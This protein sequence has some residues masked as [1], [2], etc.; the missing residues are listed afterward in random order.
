[1]KRSS[2]KL[3]YSQN[4]L[5]NAIAKKVTEQ[6]KLSRTD[7]VVEIG[8]GSGQ[9]T[10]G[11]VKKVAAVIAIEQDY[12]LATKLGE[13]IGN[14]I[15]LITFCG[16]FLEFDLP[17]GVYKVVGNIPF[18]HTAQIVRKLTS[19]Q[20]T[21]ESSYLI[22]QLEAAQR[23]AGTPLETLQSLKLKAKFEIRVLMHLSPYAFI[24]RPAVSAALV[25][26]K[27]REVMA[28]RHLESY[29]TLVDQAFAGN[30]R[31][32]FR[33]L[34]KR[35]GYQRALQIQSESKVNLHRLRS[36]ISFDEWVRIAAFFD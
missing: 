2:Y 30:Y 9:L 23:Y 16:N 3:K 32:L 11:I 17:T 20:N 33:F 24:P 22:M 25:L 35:Y 14:P 31:T 7:K 8:P 19:Q 12:N 27:S 29:L 26:L 28:G 36:R 6:I 4:F 18:A 13:R 10:R 21:P 34:Q 5:K 15:N 1:M